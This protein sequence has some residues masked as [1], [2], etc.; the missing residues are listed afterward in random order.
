MNS[1]L[2]GPLAGR[3]VLELCSTVAGPACARLLGD[4][5]AEVFKI[6]PLEGDM[7]RHMGLHEGDVSL[8]AASILRNKRSIAI[9]LRTEEGRAL[10]LAIA[11]RCDV[12]VENFRPG[13]MERL[14]LGYDALAA[15][16]PRLVY[17]SLS[18]MGADGPD[19]ETGAFDLTIQAVGGF[20]SI[21]GERGGA[22]V[23]TA[24]SIPPGVGKGH[25]PC[26]IV[27]ARRIAAR[28]FPPT[29]IGGCGTCT[30]RGSAVTDLA[31]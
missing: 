5:G 20:M 22:E 29:Q 4:Y 28:L 31:T 17:A 18:G 7:V 9:D 23:L 1:E 25:H 3:R 26:A 8:Y 21:T 6:E 15:E 24:R 10:A 14:G 12:V 13:V 19:A 11:A 30:G 16:N 27:T 2:F